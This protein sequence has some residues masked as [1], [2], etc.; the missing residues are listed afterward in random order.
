MKPERAVILYFPAI[1]AAILLAAVSSF[2]YSWASTFINLACSIQDDSFYYFIPAWNGGHGAGLTFGGE[3]TSGFQPLYEVLLTTLSPLC[4]SLESLVR[5][6]ISLNGCLFASTALLIGLSVRPLTQAL[7][8]RPTNAAI[9][10]SMSVAAFS[11]LCL[12]TVYFSS[13]TGKEN[14]LAALLL[15]AIIWVLLADRRGLIAS[16]A[17]GLLCGLLLVT[18]IAPASILYVGIAI[19]LAGNWRARAIAMVACL[20]P[21]GTW[22]VFAHAYFGHVLPMSMLVKVAA[23]SH[24][25]IPQAIRSGLKYGWESIRFSL[26][27][28]SRFNIPAL[29]ARVGIRSPMQ[30]ILMALALGVS[31]FALLRSLLAR[32]ISRPLVALLALDAGGIACNIVFG[33]AQAGHSD[34]MYYSV[35]YVFDLPVLIA[36]NCGYAFAWAQ[37]TLPTLHSTRATA[38]LAVACCAYFGGDV[39]WYAQLQPYGPADDAKFAP[40]WPAKKYE[41]ADWFRRNVHPSHPDYKVVAFS[42]GAVSYYLFDHVVNLDGL[43]NDAAGAALV[44]THSVDRY[45]ESIRPD[46]LI[47]ICSGETHFT[48]LER[49][50]VIS[51]P[52][53]GDYCIDRFIYDAARPP[54]REQGK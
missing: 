13:V 14:A 45:A 20:L 26:S 22:A 29:Q 12:H 43:A 16:F 44:S 42:A 54:E 37:S 30:I 39:A 46:Y 53:Q 27:A 4:S 3:K 21:L 28:T 48:H 51:F 49:L 52:K 35:W 15:A 10:L 34:D 24:L 38:V 9:A 7:R 47:E 11:F 8:P 5:L 32:Q 17:I 33:M 41:V 50:H 40:T 2:G 23:P 18:R 6:S 31:A 36:I 1:L 25:S 19:A